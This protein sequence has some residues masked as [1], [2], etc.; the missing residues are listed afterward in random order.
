LKKSKTIRKECDE[1]WSEAI[2]KRDRICQRPNCP[3]C[4]NQEEMKYLQAHHII[5]RTCWA[6]RYDL[7]NGIL[8]CRSSHYKWVHADDP[9]ILI[10]V[11]EFYNEIAD[12]EYL[13]ITRHRQSKNDYQ[14]IKLYL[15]SRL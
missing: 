10:D 5:N 11:H 14:L 6:L 7:E 2:K 8:L 4:F 12:M 13:K 3:Y 15:K 9:F 1:L